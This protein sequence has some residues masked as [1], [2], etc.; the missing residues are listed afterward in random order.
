[1][2]PIRAQLKLKIEEELTAEVLK[3]KGQAL[4]KVYIFIHEPRI[5]KWFSNANIKEYLESE[6][7]PELGLLFKM[8]I[9]QIIETKQWS[10]GVHFPQM[11][12]KAIKVL[13]NIKESNGFII[14]NGEYAAMMTDIIEIDHFHIGKVL[15]NMTAKIMGIPKDSGF[16]QFVPAAVR[17]TLAYPTPIQTAKDFDIVLKG[18]LYKALKNTLGEKELLQLISKDAT[19]NGTPIAKLLDQINENLKDTKAVEKVKSSFAGGVYEDGLPWSGVLAE[20]DTKQHHWKFAAHIANKEPKNVPALI[21]EYKKKSKNKNKIELAWNGGYIL[22]PELVGKLGLPE[23]YIGSPLGL[24]I[25]NNKVFC[26]PLFNK[27]A[28]VIYKNGDVDIRKVNSKAG[29]IVKGKQNI[30]F[31]PNNYNSHSNIEPCFYDLSYSEDS[32]KGNGHVILRVA[33][34]TVKQIIKTKANEV[35]PVI[36]VGIT[37]SIPAEVYANSMFEEGKPLDIQLL[38]PETN[39]YKWDEIS[40]A[41]E[42]GPMLI[43]GGRQILNMEDEGWKTSNSIKTQ[44]ARLDFTDMRGPKIAVGITKEGKLMVLMVNGRIRE[45]VGATHFDMVDILLKYGMDKAMGFDPGGSS[46]LVVDG[47]IM[48]ISPYNKNYEKNIYS[49]PPEPR[50]VANAIMGWIEE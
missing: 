36:P 13:R 9:V 16:I 33:G 32:I 45:S 24:L 23:T 1:M 42:A 38:E 2:Q 37:L 12:A 49:L 14:T 31:A 3:E 4:E 27:P 17:T 10:E 5:T 7:E 50:F 11:G 40:Y 8:G 44:A 30:V 28:F 43:D 21:S 48:N 19:D 22:N 39:P 20:I 34:H 47:K 15:H 25:M 26:P 41:I 29:F 35:V 46:T 18:D 6:K